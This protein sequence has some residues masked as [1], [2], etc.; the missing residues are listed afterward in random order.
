MNRKKPKLSIVIIARNEAPR[1]AACIGALRGM[2][3][4]IVI[5]NGSRDDTATVAKQATARVITVTEEGFATLRNHAMRFVTGDWVLYVDADEIVTPTLGQAMARGIADDAGSGVAGY[6]L[7]RKN[8][9]LGHPWPGGEWMLRLFRVAAFR[10]WEGELHETARVD[11]SVKR[12]D[13][14]L[15]H[16]THRTLSEMVNKTNE[17]SETEATLRLVAHHPPMTWWR[18]IRVTLTGFLH[19]FFTLGGWR[20][21]TVGWIESMYQGFSMFITYAK[22]WELQQKSSHE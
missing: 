6:E 10:G 20:A 16:D 7:Y 9:Y 12:L 11:G 17:W 5:D 1:I 8:Y 14:E 19:S 2:G 3:E 18:M 4:I 21:G 13:G 15:L 22:L